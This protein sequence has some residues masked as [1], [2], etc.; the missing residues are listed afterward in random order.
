MYLLLLKFLHVQQCKTLHI[1]RFFFVLQDPGSHI[2]FGYALVHCVYLTPILM[3][4][5][6]MQNVKDALVKEKG[7][8]YQLLKEVPFLRPFPSYS[9]FILCKVTSVKGTFILCSMFHVLL[10]SLTSKLCL[11]R[12]V[13]ALCFYQAQTCC[14]ICLFVILALVNSS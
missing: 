7:R 12:N 1:Q 10:I 4:Q 14:K 13:M 9:N 3:W 5:L 8:L 6:L 11:L 2:Y